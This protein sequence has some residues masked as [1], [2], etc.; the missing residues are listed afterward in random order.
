MEA[1][2]SL[3]SSSTNTTASYTSSWWKWGTSNSRRQRTASSQSP[4]ERYSFRRRFIY[5]HTHGTSEERYRKEGWNEQKSKYSTPYT[6]HTI[7]GIKNTSRSSLC[8]TIYMYLKIRQELLFHDKEDI[9]LHTHTH[10][11]CSSLLYLYII[12]LLYKKF[13]WQCSYCFMWF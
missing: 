5:M 2:S 13:L 10:I 8:V 4:E 7:V 3:A 9:P 6:Q 1:V 11:S 12:I